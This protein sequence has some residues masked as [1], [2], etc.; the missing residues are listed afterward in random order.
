MSASACPRCGG[1]EET[2]GGPTPPVNDA[3]T[4]EQLQELLALETPPTTLTPIRLSQANGDF[5]PGVAFKLSGVPLPNTRFF[6]LRNWSTTQA[7]SYW[8]IGPAGVKQPPTKAYNTLAPAA[9]SSA[10][11][12]IALDANPPEVLLFYP[13]ATTDGLLEALFASP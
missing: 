7:L 5:Q 13:A 8:F 10:P 1:R 6:L 11:S 2:L 9:S 3:P 12:Q 4:W